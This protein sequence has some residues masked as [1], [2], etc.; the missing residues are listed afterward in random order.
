MAFNKVQYDNDYTRQNYD[1]IRA[2]VPK[3]RNK[4]IKALAASQGKSVSQLIV[5]ALE[6]YYHIDLSKP[7]GG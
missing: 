1:V 7:N 3:G 5:E 6:G 2:L 4:D